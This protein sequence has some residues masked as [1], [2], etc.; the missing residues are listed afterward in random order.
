MN[1]LSL[2][3]QR[4]QE[5]G[6][7][8]WYWRVIV[9]V[10]AEP[11]VDFRHYELAADLEELQKSAEGEGEFFIITCFCGEP[12]CAGIQEGIKVLHQGDHVTW[13]YRN[14][15]PDPATQPELV[16]PTASRRPEWAVRGVKLPTKTF[17]FDR[18]EYVSSIMGGIKRGAQLLQQGSPESRIVPEHTRRLLES[19]GLPDR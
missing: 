17:V 3:Y 10:D 16:K 2:H 11:V 13:V 6:Q 5:P 18:A 19:F 14:P 15:L 7:D 9:K 12:Q 4:E 1:K 8:E